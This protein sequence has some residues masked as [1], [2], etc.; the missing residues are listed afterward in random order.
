MHLLCGRFYDSVTR[1]LTQDWEIDLLDGNSGH[2]VKIVG[3]PQSSV[4]LNNMIISSLDANDSFDPPKNLS[5]TVNEYSFRDNDPKYYQQEV[6]S[7]IRIKSG[8]Q[9]DEYLC[10]DDTCIIEIG[11]R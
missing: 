2:G 10:R 7:S 4:A 8:N 1:T 3:N 9:S 11:K 6:F 5:A